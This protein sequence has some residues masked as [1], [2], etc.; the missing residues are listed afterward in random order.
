[1]TSNRHYVDFLI[2]LGFLFAY[3]TTVR[4]C[5]L[6]YLLASARHLSAASAQRS[7]FLVMDSLS[8]S[9]LRGHWYILVLPAE[10]PVL[11]NPLAAVRRNRFSR[12]IN[13]IARERDT[14]C[15]GCSSVRSCVSSSITMSHTYSYVRAMPKSIVP[16]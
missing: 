12:G 15:S 4:G 8:D 9:S 11:I 1:M 14:A 16:S 13:L 2:L 6:A 3:S 5:S 7:P 10:F